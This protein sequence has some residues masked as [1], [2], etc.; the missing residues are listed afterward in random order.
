MLIYLVSYNKTIAKE[1]TLFCFIFNTCKE[2][3]RLFVP[4]LN[5]YKLRCQTC[6]SILYSRFKK[7][8]FIDYYIHS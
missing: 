1:L 3:D 7:V 5:Y 8:Q 6:L 4:K 2:N